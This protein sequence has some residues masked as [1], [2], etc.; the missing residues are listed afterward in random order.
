[1]LLF[2]ICEFYEI[3]EYDTN[4]MCMRHVTVPR[5]DGKMNM[6]MNKITC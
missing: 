5:K 2:V 6:T 1:M 4:M 3:C